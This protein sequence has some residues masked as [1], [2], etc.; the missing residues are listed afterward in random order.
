MGTFSK[1]VGSYGAFV[2]APEEI[3]QMLVNRCRTLIYST[4]LPPP[5][6]GAALKGVEIISG[7]EGDA[8][9]DRLD[10][11]CRALKDVLESSGWPLMPGDGPIFLLRAENAR[12]A[13]EAERRLR[14][15]G[16]FLRAIRYPTVP[17]G[18][19]RLRIVAGAQLTA[20]DLDRT[21]RALLEVKPS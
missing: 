11:N 12:H 16:V 2:A 19:E 14:E 8:L 18:T 10:G 6:A 15:K 1:S 21:L 7:E 5:V 13:V 3:R 4:A 9:R 20:D 17:E